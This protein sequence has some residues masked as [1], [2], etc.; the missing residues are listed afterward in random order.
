MTA[1]TQGKLVLEDGG[2]L[3]LEDNMHLL[4]ED[5]ITV[6]CNALVDPHQWNGPTAEEIRQ[7]RECINDDEPMI[8]E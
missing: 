7:Y 2:R 5:Y 1:I 8:E 3:L 4:L 6:L